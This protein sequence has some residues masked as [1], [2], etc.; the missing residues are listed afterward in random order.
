MKGAEEESRCHGRREKQ[1]KKQ[2]KREQ[3]KRLDVHTHDSRRFVLPSL[4]SPLHLV[5][6]LRVLFLLF[7]SFYDTTRFSSLPLSQAH[8]ADPSI[9]KSTF[10]THKETIELDG[11]KGENQGMK[12]KGEGKKAKEQN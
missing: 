6:F 7:S 11:E 10:T 8:P 12:E 9:D 2:Q 1:R 3:Q 4:L 5:F